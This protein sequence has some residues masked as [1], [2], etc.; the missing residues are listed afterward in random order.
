MRLHLESLYHQ[1]TCF[2]T[3]TYDQ[4]HIP[5]GETLRP[6]D[7]QLFFKRLRKRISPL[8]IRFYGVG[9]YGGRTD[10]PHYH[11]IIFGYDFPDRRVYRDCGSYTIDNSSSLERLWPLGHSTVQ[12]YSPEA[13]AYVAKYSVKK[14]TGEKAKEHYQIVEVNTGEIIQRHPE[15]ARMSRKPGIGAQWLAEYSGDLYPKGYI[16]DGKG[17]KTPPPEYFNKLF[18]KWYPEAFQLMKEERKEEN[19]ERYNDWNQARYDAREII[20]TK[21]HNLRKQQI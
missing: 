12:S 19:F 13:A 7:L 14:I 3:L 8:R 15:F 11:A 21:K 2:I 16:T 17:H 10:R 4:E 20:Q 9:E 6:E 18:E 1:R 5:H